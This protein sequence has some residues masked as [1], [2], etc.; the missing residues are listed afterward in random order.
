M[1]DQWAGAIAAAVALPKLAIISVHNT[2]DSVQKVLNTT[3]GTRF[4]KSIPGKINLCV[5]ILEDNIYGGQMNN[6][7]DS[8]PYYKH[9]KF[10]DVLRGSLNGT[11]GSE[12]SSSP[13][14]NEVHQVTYSV[15]FKQHPDWVGKNCSILAFIMNPDSKEIFH[16]AKA[17]VI[18][19]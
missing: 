12:I 15:D 2:Y 11:W 19:P 10:M 1:P 6:V 9:F 4:L 3:V 14:V 5:C 7:G 8:I 18:N 13:G 16:S 17:P